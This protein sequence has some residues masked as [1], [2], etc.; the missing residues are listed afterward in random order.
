[1]QNTLYKVECDN[2]YGRTV[3]KMLSKS[4]LGEFAFTNMYSFDRKHRQVDKFSLLKNAVKPPVLFQFT[5]KSGQPIVLRNSSSRFTPS[6][7]YT[8]V[9][10]APVR[11]T[12]GGI[13]HK[14]ECRVMVP[15]KSMFETTKSELVYYDY[16]LLKVTYDDTNFHNNA[17]V[18][19]KGHV[20]DEVVT[21]YASFVTNLKA[22]GMISDD[23]Y[24]EDLLYKV[25]GA[26]AKSQT[27][28]KGIP[29]AT[30]TPVVLTRTSTAP[31]AA[32]AQVQARTNTAPVETAVPTRT[33]STAQATT[34]PVAQPDVSGL[35]S[36]IQN[37]NERVDTLER[38]VQKLLAFQNR[39][40]NSSP[41]VSTPFNA[42]D[43]D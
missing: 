15:K 13:I 22:S 37:T 43:L 10:M 14:H 34:N 24:I 35:T 31:V 18:I 11:N 26:L 30:G 39:S 28:P 19:P 5:N 25:K 7:T 36:I 27:L 9:N 38:L 40:T 33:E 2:M 8:I 20:S 32:A 1:M 21:E 23:D 12:N 41:S 6:F 17:F 16:F 42:A 3:Q 29:V 4:A